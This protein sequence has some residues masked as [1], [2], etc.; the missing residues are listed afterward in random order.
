MV[1]HSLKELASESD[2]DKPSSESLRAASDHP[3]SSSEDTLDSSRANLEA[4]IKKE[5]VCTGINCRAQ[6]LKTRPRKVPQK[7]TPSLFW[8]VEK[9]GCKLTSGLHIHVGLPPEAHAAQLPQPTMRPTAAT[10][11]LHKDPVDAAR[12][13]ASTGGAGRLDL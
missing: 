4:A 9:P 3:S 7:K 10:P 1:A 2:S 13:A 12:S 6:H 8:G 5:R 11:S